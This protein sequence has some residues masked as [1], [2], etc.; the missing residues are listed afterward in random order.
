MG[1]EAGFAVQAFAAFAALVADCDVALAVA[2]Q[3][4]G[5]GRCPHP[6]P[7]CNQAY[8]YIFMYTRG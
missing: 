1:W 7:D 8:E 2:G 4:R 3:V 5:C 6:L